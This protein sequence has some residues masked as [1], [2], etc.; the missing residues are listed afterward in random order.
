MRRTTLVVML[1]LGLVMGLTLSAALGVYAQERGEGEREAGSQG[2]VGGEGLNDP[3]PAGYSV[4]YIFGGVANRTTGT[5]RIATSVHCTNY[6]SSPVDTRVE[7]Y[8]FRTGIGGS[9]QSGLHR[10]SG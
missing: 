4:L 1:V 10:S 5:A 9:V 3:P 8:G 7:M 2:E 6:G